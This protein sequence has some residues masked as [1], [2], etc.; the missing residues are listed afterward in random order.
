M[1]SD[2]NLQSERQW[3]AND[4]WYGDKL[5]IVAQIW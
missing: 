4:E 5:I 2:K 1:N 3:M